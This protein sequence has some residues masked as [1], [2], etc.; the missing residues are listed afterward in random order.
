VL[1][2]DASLEYNDGYP[3]TCV[4]T[5]A[6]VREILERLGYP[7][8]M[9]RIEASVHYDAHWNEA[10]LRVRLGRHT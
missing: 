9:I 5:S 10:V 4:L 8:R 2:H 6:A 3:A 1:T 7:A